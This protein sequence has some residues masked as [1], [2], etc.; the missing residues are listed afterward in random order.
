M[1]IPAL[2]QTCSTGVAEWQGPKHRESR[3]Q[4]KGTL[5]Q[6]PLTWEA[7]TALALTAACR[8]GGSTGGFV[9]GIAALCFA[10]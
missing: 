9:E 4:G 6:V 3:E 10:L 7:D 2:M 5:S 1:V 8:A